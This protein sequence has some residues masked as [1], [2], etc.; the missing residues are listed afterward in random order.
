NIERLAQLGPRPIYIRADATDRAALQAAYE[1]IKRFHQR[2]DGVVHSAIVLRDQ[3]LTKMDEDGFCAGLSAKVDV[4]VRIAQV[5]ASE[6]L[7]FVLF[8]SSLSAFGTPPGQ[9]NYAA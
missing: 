6:S 8:F 2:I 4:S 7:R 1:E 3:S 5:F 9:S